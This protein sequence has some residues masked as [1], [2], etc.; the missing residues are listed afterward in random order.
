[1]TKF[2]FSL[3]FL[4]CFDNRFFYPLESDEVMIKM[5]VQ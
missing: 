2:L 3:P 4:L 1:M 5:D